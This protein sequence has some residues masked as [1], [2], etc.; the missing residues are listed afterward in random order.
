VRALLRPA[1]PASAAEQIAE[2]E[3]IAEPAEN[4]FEADEGGWVETGRSLG[5]KAGMPEAIVG[6]ALLRIREH[7][8]R[9]GRLLEPF[10]GVLA[11]LVAIG[12][13]L[14]RELPVRRLE[15]GFRGSTLDREDLVVIDL[16]HA[17]A[18]FTM[19]GRSS[20]SLSR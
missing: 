5:A 8:V 18:T 17:W 12:M 2:A 16:T 6:R 19:A 7:R 15:I 1:A 14:E 11:A 13:V 20:R 4:V 10:L 9:F 3:G